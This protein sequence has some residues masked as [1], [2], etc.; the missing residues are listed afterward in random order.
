MTR[1]LNV[2]SNGD[3]HFFN[4]L[5]SNSLTIPSGTLT[6]DM[7]SGSAAI[8]ADKLEHQHRHTYSQEAAATAA[9]GTYAIHVCNGA[10]G[11][12]KAFKAGLVSVGS[13]SVTHTVEVDLIK[14]T[15]GGATATVL[16]GVASI[17]TSNTNYQMVAATI[18]TAAVATGDVL[19]LVIDVTTPTN[20]AGLF[21]TL[22]MYEDA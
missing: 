7:V 1:V 13:T 21:C 9:T 3:A 16:S 5:S 4:N 18:G 2:E 15:Q 6:D 8:S 20:T 19:M 22:D 17:T 10:T 14:A 11:T 12:I